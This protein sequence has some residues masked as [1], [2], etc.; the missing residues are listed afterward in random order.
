VNEHLRLH[1][2]LSEAEVE[3]QQRFDA[4]REFELGLFDSGISIPETLREWDR[5]RGEERVAYD[6]R[7]A[8]RKAYVEYLERAGKGDH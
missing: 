4:V 8:A 7:E 1:R 5:L 3:Y 6:K 2:D